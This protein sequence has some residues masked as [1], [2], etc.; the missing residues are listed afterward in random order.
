MLAK[1][2]RFTVASRIQ[3]TINLWYLLLITLSMSEIIQHKYFPMATLRGMLNGVI[4]FVIFI[5]SDQLEQ[6]NHPSICLIHCRFIL[7][8]AVLPPSGKTENQTYQQIFTLTYKQKVHTRN[9]Q[10]RTKY[11]SQL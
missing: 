8:I 7:K 9:D 11:I 2:S 1:I 6:H 10:F 3:H 4:S 5:Y